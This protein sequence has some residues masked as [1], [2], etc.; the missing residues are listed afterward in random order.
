MVNVTITGRD[1]KMHMLEETTYFL[2]MS[3]TRYTYLSTKNNALRVAYVLQDNLF[4]PW[5]CFK[6]I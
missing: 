4:R 3:R 6:Y 1:T 2:G 5:L